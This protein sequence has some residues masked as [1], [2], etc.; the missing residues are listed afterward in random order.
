LIFQGLLFYDERLK[1]QNEEDIIEENKT[2]ENSPGKYIE[3]IVARKQ[4]V[5]F[6]RFKIRT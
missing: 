5:E 3:E 6:D 1:T 4:E 2:L